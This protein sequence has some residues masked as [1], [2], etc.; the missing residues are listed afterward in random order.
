MFFV[1]RV[2][3]KW[4]HA[5]SMLG[6]GGD[7]SHFHTESPQSRSRINQIDVIS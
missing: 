7:C 5:V 1:S 3:W 2:G 4:E 6:G